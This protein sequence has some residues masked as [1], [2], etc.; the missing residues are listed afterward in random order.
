MLAA[1]TTFPIHAFAAAL[2][3]MIAGCESMPVQEMSDARQAIMA[4]RDAGAEEFA[5][6]QLLAAEASL[7]S[8]EASLNTRNYGT[9]R[10]EAVEAKALAIEA[11]QRSEAA[12]GEKK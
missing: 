3:L 8:A 9:A 11:M 1:R 2:L 4:A 10:R 12:Q 5:S 6:E 7:H